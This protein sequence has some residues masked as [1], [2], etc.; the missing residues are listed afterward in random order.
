MNANSF[1]EEENG[2]FCFGWM[3]EENKQAGIDKRGEIKRERE[4]EEG[5]EGERGG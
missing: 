4:R 3:L 2:K 5:R 1:F